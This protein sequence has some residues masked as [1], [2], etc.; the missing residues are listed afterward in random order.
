MTLLSSDEIVD[1]LLYLDRMNIDTASFTSRKFL[2]SSELVPIGACLRTFEYVKVTCSYRPRQRFERLRRAVRRLLRADTRGSKRLYLHTKPKSEYLRVIYKLRRLEVLL[3]R[4]LRIL[5]SSN[6]HL[7]VIDSG[8]G[9]T[10]PTYF[11]HALHSNRLKTGLVHRL[12]FRPNI[13]NLLIQVSSV[14]L[15]LAVF[16]AITDRI[17]ASW[18][19]KQRWLSL[20]L[21]P[22]SR[23]P[24]ACGL[25][26]GLVLEE[27]LPK[28]IPYFL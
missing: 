13:G 14:V 24:R 8:P 9:C 21:Q 22:G 11:L 19:V 10:L 27:I 1:V 12:H 23:G 26:L 3:E 16:V 18:N 4:L 5:Q 25:G 7:L 17:S 6:I 28:T 15:K 20:D 2:H